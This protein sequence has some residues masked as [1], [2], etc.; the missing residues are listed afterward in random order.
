MLSNEDQGT[1][2]MSLEKEIRAA[3]SQHW[4]TSDANDFATEHQI[5]HE[6]AILDDPQSEERIRG[7]ANIQESRTL[8]ANKKRFK[9]GRI[10]GLDSLWITEYILY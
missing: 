10:I 4:A 8:Q 6:D 2:A 1:Q 9:I 3:L 5:Y 7:R